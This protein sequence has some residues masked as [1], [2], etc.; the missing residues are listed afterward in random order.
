MPLDP[1]GGPGN[2]PRIQATMK[3]SHTAKNIPNINGAKIA[4][5]QSKWYREYTDKM[6]ERCI[7]LLIKA[8]APRPEVHIIPGSLELPIAAQ[9]L[10]A[11]KA[12][13]FE[14]LICFGA[15]LK[16]ETYHFEMVMNECIR[17]L[18]STALAHDIPILVEV[19]PCT[20]VEQL[21][22][23]S[24]PDEFNKGIEA[25]VAAAEIVAWR[26]AQKALRAL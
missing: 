13:G 26:R 2:I 17:G 3:T 12:R 21:I 7:D 5:L 24:G 15:I 8:G 18:G 19:L 23:R 6:V 14:A 10:A 1:Y 22:K 20:S 9:T 16:G 4:V 11:D 25:A